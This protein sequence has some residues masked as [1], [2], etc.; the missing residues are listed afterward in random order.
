MF[1]LSR[2]G[3]LDPA[4]SVFVMADTTDA[5]SDQCARRRHIQAAVATLPGFFYLDVNCALHQY[6]LIIKDNLQ[7]LDD[8]LKSLPPEESQGF[9]AYAANLAK[10]TNFWR[11]HVSSFI[12]AWEAVHGFGR[13]SART[14]PK[15][16]AYRRFPLAVISGRW[17]SVESCES[18]FIERSRTLLEPVFLSVLSQYMKA[19]PKKSKKTSQAPA[20]R[21]T[22]VDVQ[23][24]RSNDLL[25]Q[26]DDRDAYHMKLSKWA[27]GSLKTI[28]SS[29]FCGCFCMCRAAHG[30]HFRISLHGLRKILTTASFN[31]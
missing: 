21:P 2:E 11:S 24:R 29:L 28:R 7:I 31:N 12:D 25:D 26:A 18:F 5:G 22:D 4:A 3:R 14:K 13:V 23:D 16:V 27:D 9:Q 17:G 6:H 10:C 1:L 8:F 20:Q 15:P 19:G 30:H